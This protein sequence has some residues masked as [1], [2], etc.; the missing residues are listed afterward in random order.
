MLTMEEMNRDA[1]TILAMDNEGIIPENS[2][3]PEQKQMFN[4][5]HDLT[6]WVE[7]WKDDLVQRG[8]DIS[9]KAA[10][11][12]EAG[13][14][15][16]S[17]DDM[18]LPQQD[19]SPL[20]EN[21][22]LALQDAVDDARFAATKQPLSFTG[23][24]AGAF[25]SPWIPLAV[26]GA[27]MAKELQMAQRS[28]NAPAMSDQAKEALAPMLLGSMAAALTHG[29]GSLLKNVAP[30][31][32][33]VLTTPFVG[34]GVAVGATM[35]YDDNIANY[36]K[37]HPQRFAV[38]S[39]TMDAAL[40]A[41]K[42]A[43]MDWSSKTN[44]VTDT[45]AIAR[46]VNPET[47]EATDVRS[48][49]L[50]NQAVGS[51]TKPIRAV[52]VQ[53]VKTKESVPVTPKEEAF[54]ERRP[55]IQ[56]SQDILA[57][58][59]AEE[60]LASKRIEETMQGAYGEKLVA[61]TDNL[62]PTSVSINQIWAMFKKL[63]PAR[64]NNMDNMPDSTLGFFN[65]KGRGIRV[66]GFRPWSV[67]CH[68]LGHAIS[69]EFE[70]ARGAEVEAELA[71]GAHSIWSHGEYGDFHSPEGFATYVEE[72]RAAFMN[73]YLI[74]PEMAKKHFP[75]TYEAFETAIA[76]DVRWSGHMNT[77]GQMVRRWCNMNTMQKA[78][79]SKHWGDTTDRSVGE[80][81]ADMKNKVE[82]GYSDEF[83]PLR[84]T[85]E[86]FTETYGE[87]PTVEND[88]AV[89][90]QRAKESINAS[91][92]VMIDG[93]GF[94]TATVIPHL[95]N[96]FGTALYNV[97]L[98]DVFL[99]FSVGGERGK[100]LK[101]LLQKLGVK[102]FYEAFSNYQSAKH[103]LELIKVKNAER[104]KKAENA[105]KTLEKNIQ[106]LMP[107]MDKVNNLVDELTMTYAPLKEKLDSL[108]ISKRETL[109]SL[110]DL[111]S[112]IAKDTNLIKRLE[113]RLETITGKVG[114]TMDKGRNTAQRLHR[115]EQLFPKDVAGEGNKAKS[116]SV[117]L[118]ENGN[119]LRP[120]KMMMGRYKQLLKIYY[121]DVTDFRG[122]ADT[123]TKELQEAKARLVKNSSEIEGHKAK[124]AE[125]TTQL[126]ELD[127]VIQPLGK[128][129]SKAKRELARLEEQVQGLKEQQRIHTKK[130]LDINA[131]RDDYA[132]SMTR[133]ENAEILEM[134]KDVPEFEQ[135]SILWKQWHENVLRIAVA[136]GI[137]PKKTMDYF[138]KTY[139]EYIPL[140]RDF[141]IEGYDRVYG[142]ITHALSE[143]GSSRVVQDP[144]TQ[145]VLDVKTVM[146]KVERNRVGQALAKMSKGEYGHYLMMKVPEGKE[147]AAHQIITVWEDGKPT[148]Y[149]CMADGLYDAY[150]ST[151]KAF[152]E[153]N[154]D[155]ITKMQ[156]RLATTLRIGATSTPA[157]AVWNLE[158]D[159]LDATIL[160]TDGRMNKFLSLREPLAILFEGLSVALSDVKTF[161]I[162][163]AMAHL[164]KNNAANRNIKAE[165]MVQGVQYTT[166]L[167]H[168]RDITGR[169]RKI[170]TP[171]SNFDKVKN[172]VSKPIKT[173]MAFNEACEQIARMGLY[174]RARKRGGSAIEAA[175][176]ASDSTVN[177]MRSGTKT[178]QINKITP[179]FNATIQGGLKFFKEYRKDPIGVTMAAFECLTLPTLVLY[180]LNKDED[181]YRDMS[182]DQKNKAWYVKVN[183]TI[184]SFAKP[185]VLG[186][187]F[188]SLPERILDVMYQGDDAEAADDCLIKA[189][190]GFFP[191]YVS[192]PVE[193]VLE[194]K[195]NYNFYKDRP[196]VDQRLG[197]VS[198]KYQYNVYTSEMA[199][200]IGNLL[201]VSPM[202]V[203]NTFYG[204]TGSLGYAF[205]SVADWA[206]KT[207]ETPD[208][209]WTEYTRFTYTE[210][211][212]Q[213]RSQDIFYKGLDSLEKE[214][215]DAKLLGTPLKDTKALDGMKTSSELVKLITNG[216]KD[217][218]AKAARKKLGKWANDPDVRKGLRA[219]E[220][221]PNLN[222]AE[223]RAKID[224]LVK[225][226]NNIYR[227]ANKKYLNQKYIQAPE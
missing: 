177:F 52:E 219:I 32:S 187:L 224:K 93:N 214:S 10:A 190:Q 9:N 175:T 164:D 100:F 31:A 142:S 125:V 111:Q 186:Q 54:P 165:Y 227:T 166:K 105:I 34:S 147:A 131:G 135:A 136:G 141:T 20:Q 216:V 43:K 182:L 211:G 99:P 176:V 92:A 19:M 168:P 173:Y 37:E 60:I 55:D 29:G 154:L 121:R 210:G 158:R 170:V 138:L 56:K 191:S 144:F 103:E 120:N 149:Q 67:L 132:T 39:F 64:P 122:M 204:L 86:G 68:E 87:K 8:Q 206:L 1:S 183:G 114:K 72:G 113:H 23:D 90:A 152:V 46:T 12:Y 127:P 162:G 169:L 78:S 156:E 181:W 57:D 117:V 116:N 88:P 95:A 7:E 65:I 151:N 118:D 128:Q 97:V 40:G 172:K 180:Y 38:Q 28:Q 107:H 50:A 115:E 18:A 6:S 26:Q 161:G 79:G 133:H 221:D 148:Y 98:S 82:E 119:V 83:A 81:I 89:L 130:I 171:E 202:K 203:D 157:F 217:K 62:Y 198:D 195:A 220:N 16:D 69:K 225:L 41:K 3:T 124:L 160:N 205:N 139:P 222:G 199:K 61:S 47:G 13:V 197:K 218:N 85:V 137:L 101:G 179:F 150:T 153:M 44:P 36:A 25:V 106:L 110:S 209:K 58:A 108:N 80:R 30:R 196:I 15:P 146:S 73:E 17:I 24:V 167:S 45:E 21:V 123:I 193:K 223:K 188:A 49:I 5:L 51:P 102:D 194:W 140:K 201:N 185:P 178:K 200:G 77:I 70:F 94:D 163:K 134:C 42:L 76:S 11:A 109:H 208:R 184:L 104:I 155:I 212:R 75:L 213:T 96:K 4:P 192:P 84:N 66:R 22:A 126:K 129:L 2:R 27:I 48:A 63:V 145:A 215:N 189:V 91:E 174:K 159:L 53:P 35:A 14:L 33:K 74:N 207:N 71:K 143:E 112:K 59:T 226:R